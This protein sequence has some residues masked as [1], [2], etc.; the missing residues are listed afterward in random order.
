[1]KRIPVKEAKKAVNTIIAFCDEPRR[2]FECELKE[3]CSSILAGKSP[4][5]CEMFTIDR[6]NQKGNRGERSHAE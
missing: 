5:E 6:K 1:M 2:C 3:F 4:Y